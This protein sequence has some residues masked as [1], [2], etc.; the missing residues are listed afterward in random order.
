MSKVSV[1]NPGGFNATLMDDLGIS[2]I[3]IVKLLERLRVALRVQVTPAEFLSCVTLEDLG[4]LLSR[5]CGP[6]AKT[7]IVE[8]SYD[9]FEYP[10]RG[11]MMDPSFQ[12]IEAL[13]FP[14]RD[15]VD[16]QPHVIFMTG[17]TGYLGKY[18]LKRLLLKTSAVVVCLV[19][20]RAWKSATLLGAANLE[21]VQHFLPRVQIVYGDLQLDRFGLN[22][23]GMF[24]FSCAGEPS[25]C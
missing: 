19:R 11:L 5:K 6:D 25:S 3:Q 4:R 9:R 23:E 22:I 1:A 16:S 13:T 12:A 24:D 17:A 15:T 8:D 21:E 20:N 10:M 7:A 14:I 2:S 18:L